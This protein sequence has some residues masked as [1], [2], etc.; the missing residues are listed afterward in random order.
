MEVLDIFKSDAFSVVSMTDA[1]NKAP[2]VPGRAGA[3]IPWDESGVPTTTIMIE[4]Y[5]GELK[6][7]NPVPRGGPGE[8]S[9]KIKRTARSIVIPHYQHD[10]AVMADELQGVRE[11]GQGNQMR[12]VQSYVN[13]RLLEHAQWK[14]DPTLEHQRVGAVKGVILNGDGSTLMSLFTEFGVTQETEV[15]FDLANATPAK[16]VLRKA[17]ASVVRTIAD[18]LG[19]A[20]FVGVHAFCGSTFFDELLAHP[21]VIDSYKQTPMAQVLREGYVYPNGEM[22]YGAFE[23]GGI[24]WENYRGAIGGTAFVHAD[25]AHIF[26]M[27]TPGLWRTAYAPADYVE[28]VKTI[29]LPR[30]AKQYPMPNGKGVSLESQMNALNFCTR[31]KVLMQGKRQA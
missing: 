3:L 7:L 28:T 29:G 27:G 20:P 10:D 21:E 6:L 4:E 18:N 5:Q 17:C 24:V 1:I 15:A 31:P 2:F 8:T 11:F 16:G 13:Q 26:P 14:L 9:S 19:G 30:Y 22:V 25:K 23:F 12:T